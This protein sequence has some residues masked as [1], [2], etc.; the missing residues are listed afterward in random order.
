MLNDGSEPPCIRKVKKE[1]RESDWKL[2][3]LKAMVR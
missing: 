2:K 3:E 1:K